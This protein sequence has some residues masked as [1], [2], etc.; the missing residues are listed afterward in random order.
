MRI[1]TSQYHL[2]MSQT[3]QNAQ[4]SLERVMQQ[5]SSGQRLLLPSDDPVSSVRLSR[6]A[7]E[8]AALSQY[9]D[10]IGALS[11]RLTQNE[12]A[13]DSALEDMLQV[14]DLMVWASD[15]ANTSADVN[16]M[17]A[18]LVSL[19]DSLLYTANTRDNEGRYLFSGTKSDQPAIGFDGTNYTYDGNDDTQLVTVGNGVTQPANVNLRE[20]AELLNQINTSIAAMQTPGVNVNDPAVRAALRANLEGVDTALSAVNSKIARLGGQQNI[21]ATLDDTHGNVSVANQQAMIR[22]GELDYA[23]A[24]TRL[25]GFASALEATQKAYS[26]VSGLSLFNVL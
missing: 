17:A 2:T 19:R 10:N 21:L 4:A 25:N 5:M 3:L 23:E 22:L 8:E 24:A 18:S 9:R 11:T 14:R 20:M 7:R 16:A 26:K 6:M 12:T 15:G 13:L 1:A